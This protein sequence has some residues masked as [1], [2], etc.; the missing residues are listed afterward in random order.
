M[1]AVS[2]AEQ[3]TWLRQDVFPAR[4]AKA[5]RERMTI[6]FGAIRVYVRDHEVSEETALV[7]LLD[8]V[9]EAAVRGSVM[10]KPG[11]YLMKLMLP[12]RIGRYHVMVDSRTLNLFSYSNLT[13]TPVTWVHRR[14]RAAGEADAQ[15][16]LKMEQKEAKKR[17]QKSA[18]QSLCLTWAGR[19]VDRPDPGVPLRVWRQLHHLN[20][21]AMV[22]NRAVADCVYFSNV[23]DKER[24][25]SIQAELQL[26]LAGLTERQVRPRAEGFTIEYG[27]LAWHLRRDGRLL[28]QITIRSGHAH[29]RH[30]G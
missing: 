10:T 13:G 24:L 16:L 4:E 5:L 1:T 20:L 28:E 7:H 25:R 19:P 15:A 3:R 29:A 23:P 18:T 30:T 21:N 11:E 12:G 26:R 14:N 17:R 8:L 9:E 2:E 27:P 22:C 6:L